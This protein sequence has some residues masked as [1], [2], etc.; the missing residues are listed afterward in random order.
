MVITTPTPVPDITCDFERNTDSHDLLCGWTQEARD[1]LDWT[2]WQ[3]ASSSYPNGPPSDH[4][5]GT[6]TG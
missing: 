2:L 5:T 1:G 3:G 6:E 4:T